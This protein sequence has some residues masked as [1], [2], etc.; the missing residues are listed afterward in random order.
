MEGVRYYTSWREWRKIEYNETEPHPTC[1]DHE[2]IGVGRYANGNPEKKVMDFDYV[3][4]CCIPEM[5]DT[6]TRP[7]PFEHLWGRHIELN[8]HYWK[9]FLEA[10][11][12]SDHKFVTVDLSHSNLTAREVPF[13]IRAFGNRSL[14]SMDVACNIIDAFGV[15]ML[16]E[17]VCRYGAS[18]N[19]ASQN[20]GVG[21]VDK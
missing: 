5:L 15:E 13:L 12:D 20:I 9:M 4:A 14:Q 3:R 7:F 11:G 18:L 17:G 19:A 1:D 16:R 6:L 8:C 21:I 10:I 2:K